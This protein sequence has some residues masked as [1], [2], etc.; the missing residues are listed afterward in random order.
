MHLVLNRAVVSSFKLLILHNKFEKVV[1]SRVCGVCQIHIY[2]TS[3]IGFLY[4]TSVIILHSTV[5]RT[6]EIV[7]VCC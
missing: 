4:D 2:L 6:W 7:I 1:M 3:V 5:I